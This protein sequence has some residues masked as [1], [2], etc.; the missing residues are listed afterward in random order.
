MKQYIFSV[1]QQ[2]GQQKQRLTQDRQNILSAND[3]ARNSEYC[4][5]SI[6]KQSPEGNGK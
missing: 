1:R 2:I 4:R 3:L 6:C 5:K